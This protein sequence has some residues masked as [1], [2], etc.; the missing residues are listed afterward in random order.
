MAELL[1]FYKFCIAAAMHYRWIPGYRI[2]FPEALHQL[3]AELDRCVRPS[4]GVWP[5]LSGHLNLYC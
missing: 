5:I 2:Y 3:Q 4:R 1:S